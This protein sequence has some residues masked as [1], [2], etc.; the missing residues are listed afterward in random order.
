MRFFN[1][2]L[3]NLVIIILIFGISSF[4]FADE[5]VYSTRKKINVKSDKLKVDNVKNYAEFIGNVTAQYDNMFVSADK[6]GISYN[7]VSLGGGISGKG[8]IEKISAFGNVKIKTE[9]YTGYSD[10]AEYI[11]KSE[12]L[13][14][15]GKVCKVIDDENSIEGSRIV[16]NKKTGNVTVE[17]GAASRVETV[18]YSKE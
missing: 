10:N 17:G 11:V 6:V 3:T 5:K 9:Q 2:K 15:Q 14:L 12:T 8:G 16:L 18:F 1:F 4:A 13:I 7:K